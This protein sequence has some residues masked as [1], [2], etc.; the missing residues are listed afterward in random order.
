MYAVGRGEGHVLKAHAPRAVCLHGLHQLGGEAGAAVVLDAD[1]H[2]VVIELAEPF[3]VQDRIL[4][5]ERHKGQPC[6]YDLGFGRISAVLRV[7][8]ERAF[9][10]F[11]LDAVAQHLAADG[12]CQLLGRKRAL[13]VRHKLA[14]TRLLV[15]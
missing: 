8:A 7:D 4:R 13:F 15:T 11:C 5:L 6:V 2:H 3:A 12:F 10:V 9:A 14:P 1:R